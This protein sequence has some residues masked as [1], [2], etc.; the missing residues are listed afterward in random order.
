MNVTDR[1]D[2]FVSTYLQANKNGFFEWIT[3]T[4]AWLYSAVN[5]KISEEWLTLTREFIRLELFFLE[6]SSVLFFTL[7][8][9]HLTTEKCRSEW[10]ISELFPLSYLL[11]WISDTEAGAWNLSKMTKIRSEMT[12]AEEISFEN[13]SYSAKVGAFRKSSS[14]IL[15]DVATQTK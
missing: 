6:A 7:L 15:F 8:A 9:Q 1:D 10:F 3:H 14:Q 4:F 13:L 12:R 11:N 2:V 5:S